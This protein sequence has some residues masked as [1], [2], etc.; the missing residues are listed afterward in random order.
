MFHGSLFYLSG[1]NDQTI[2]FHCGGELKDWEY[3]DDRWVEHAKWILIC[4]YVIHIKG[5]SF[6]IVGQRLKPAKMN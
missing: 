3:L 2:C 5:L 6:V 4:L 1:K